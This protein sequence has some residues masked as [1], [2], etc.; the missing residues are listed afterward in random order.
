MVVPYGSM[1]HIPPTNLLLLAATQEPYKKSLYLSE[2]YWRIF[3]KKSRRMDERAEKDT[4]TFEQQQ[5]KLRGPHSNFQ[6]MPKVMP[7]Y[8]IDFI[9]PKLCDQP[10]HLIHQQEQ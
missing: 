1:L 4:G 3:W 8:Q 2:K 5:Q 6:I 10:K 7:F 9:W